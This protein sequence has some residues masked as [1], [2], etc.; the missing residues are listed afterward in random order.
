MRRIVKLAALVL[1]G[2][3]AARVHAEGSADAK[4]ST[5]LTEINA[6]SERGDFGE[7]QTQRTKLGEYAGSVGQFELAARQYELLL[8]A[9]PG[10]SDRV[11][12]STKLGRMYVA[13]G[14]Y[15]RAIRAFD[16]AL[17]DHDGPPLRRDGRFSLQW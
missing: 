16:D 11:R 14:D 15:S 4:I 5:A 2:G 7:V 3:I 10:R 9:R 13:L 1:A 12:F 17:H 8:A 6:A